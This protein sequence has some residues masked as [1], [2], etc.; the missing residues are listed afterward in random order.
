MFDMALVA[1]AIGGLFFEGGNAGANGFQWI[2]LVQQSGFIVDFD[3]IMPP[4][5]TL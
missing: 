1:E 3:F 5:T 4:A 2:P